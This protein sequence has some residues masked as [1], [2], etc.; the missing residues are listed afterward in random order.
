MYIYNTNYSVLNTFLFHYMHTSL[1]K[2][3]L[4]DITK[5]DCSVTCNLNQYTWVNRTKN[6]RPLGLTAPPFIRYMQNTYPELENMF[7]FT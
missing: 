2:F 6:K 5:L 1:D 4:Y 7:E 3:I